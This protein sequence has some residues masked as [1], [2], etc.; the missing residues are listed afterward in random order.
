MKK[1]FNAAIFMVAAVLVIASCGKTSENRSQVEETKVQGTEYKITKE[2]I[3]DKAQYGVKI[4]DKQTIQNSY[5]SMSYLQGYFIADCVN[6]IGGIT[7]AEKVL[8]NPKNGKTLM[9]D[10]TITY[11]EDGY[12]VGKTDDKTNLYFPKTEVGFYAL[13]DYVVA[14]NVILTKGY[15]DWGAYTTSNDTILGPNF[16]QI[17]LLEKSRQYLIQ[18]DGVWLKLNEKGEAIAQVSA[19]ELKKLKKQEKWQKNAGAF[20][21]NQ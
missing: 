2:I 11:C 14:G 4:G 15:K 19:A 18:Q 12:F 21:L 3:S 5:D 7:L 6:D 20:V 10:D 1:F 8:L 16:K 17:I 9:T 13:S